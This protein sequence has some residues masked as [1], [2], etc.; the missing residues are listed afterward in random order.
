MKP[1]IGILLLLLAGCGGGG[2]TPA[3]PPVASSSSMSSSSSVPSSP[4]RAVRVETLSW[5]T[6]PA[7]FGDLYRPTGEADEPLPVVVMIHGG[8]WQAQYDLS[9]QAGLSRALAERGFAV[10]NIEYRRLGNGGEWP[11]MFQDVARATDYLRTLAG[12]YPL[13]TA[14]VTAVGHSAGGHLALWLAGRPTIDPD[15]AI[16]TPDPLALRGA[17]SLGGVADLTAGA[18]GNAPRR[19]IEADQLDSAALSERLDNSSP[20]QMLPIDVPTRL[21]TGEN[22]S[23]VAPSISIDYADAAQ[24]AGDDSE[25]RVIDGA[26]HFALIDAGFMD[27]DELAQT[28]RA[29]AR[30]D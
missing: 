3:S 12:D 18:C 19:I 15:S 28:L 23:T 4:D 22:D 21:L 27:M 5:G 10:W 2:Q 26:N 25:H 1:I 29:L 6:G 14:R 30:P 11:V 17:V 9:L 20:R 24:N 16:H 7:Q 13:D 8:C